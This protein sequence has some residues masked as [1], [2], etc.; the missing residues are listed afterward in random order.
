MNSNSPV[1][2]NEVGGEPWYSIMAANVSLPLECNDGGDN[3]NGILFV[4][5]LSAAECPQFVKDCAIT[6]I[7]TVAAGLDVNIP[8]VSSSSSSSDSGGDNKNKHVIQGPVAEHLVVACHDHPMA[9]ILE[10]L[11]Q[12]LEFID[13]A[14]RSSNAKTGR[15]RVLVHCASGVSRS[16]TVCAAY[17][18]MVA[19]SLEQKVGALDAIASI[20]ST[21]RYANPNLGFRRQLAVLEQ[22]ITK[23]SFDMDKS[24]KQDQ[25]VE[26]SCSLQS[27]LAIINS[28]KNEYTKLQSNVVEDTIQQRTAVNE[29][30]AK[31][32]VLEERLAT[33][34][35]KT[36]ANK[37][38]VS[39]DISRNSNE[40]DVNE[41][42][43]LGAEHEEIEKALLL[44]Q[45]ELDVCLPMESE[46]LVDPAARMIRRAAISKIGRLLDTLSAE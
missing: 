27:F 30:H 17:I 14:L 4:G 32:D 19:Y 40:K 46:G 21:R 6:H 37:M 41:S 23:A 11:P 7:L 16:V 39:N 35:S 13:A 22:H 43:E 44:V 45:E 28:A 18:M 2:R 33:M 1:G 15:G 24:G 9:N 31:V 12:C 25:A 10:V 36:A 34:I 8:K 20:A 26:G 3:E 42:K 38:N 29:L 5:S